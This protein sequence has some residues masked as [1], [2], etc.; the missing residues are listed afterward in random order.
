MNNDTRKYIMEQQGYSDE[1]LKF[2]RERTDRHVALVKKYA[3]ELIKMYPQY[4]DK[5]IENVK[6]HDASKYEE[7]ERTPYIHITWMYKTK[8]TDNPYKI[9]EAIDD[10]VAT[11]HHVTNN[12]HHPEYYTDTDIN[13]INRKDR[14]AIPD[15]IIDATKMPAHAILEMVADWC[16]M[17]EEKG[18]TPQ[19]WADM[20]VNKRWKFTP[21]QVDLIYKAMENVW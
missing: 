19:A 5:L 1:M 12:P 9:P 3:G 6:D 10:Q 7:P 15:H 16:A 8:D 17:S 14:D 21:A 2:F 4:A 18:N 11:Y 13:A 20:V